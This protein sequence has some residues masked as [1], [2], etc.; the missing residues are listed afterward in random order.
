MTTKNKNLAIWE[1]VEKTN[2][3]FTKEAKISGRTITTINAMYQIE[4]ATALFGSYGAGF[5]ISD[6][7]FSEKVY[8]NETLLVAHAT[9][10]YVLEEKKHSF[11]ISSALKMIYISASNR[12]IID[13][14][15]YKKIETD[16]ITKSLSRLGFSADIFKGK[17]DDNKY[18]NDIIA[19]FKEKEIEHILQQIEQAQNLQQLVDIYSSVDSSD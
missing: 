9:F 18:I 19:E 7:Q 11:P 4:E 5:G 2:P 8:Q 16:I 12:L 14:V 10:F 15:A 3:K 17:Y 6:I 1:Q 13:V